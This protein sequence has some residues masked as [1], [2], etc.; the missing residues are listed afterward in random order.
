MN[1]K[2]KK[3]INIYIA[4][5]CILF[6]SCIPRFED[7]FYCKS[8]DTGIKFNIADS[9][10]GVLEIGNSGP[11]KRIDCWL[12]LY[13][14]PTDYS[15]KD[16]EFF[17][18]ARNKSDSL[19][20]K[21]TLFETRN[22]INNPHGLSISSS[23]EFKNL[24]DYSKTIHRESKYYSYE[25]F[26]FEIPQIHFARYNLFELN[27]LMSVNYQNKPFSKKIKEVFIRKRKFHFR[28]IGIH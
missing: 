19:I 13:N 22:N 14:L 11:W 5:I 16:L 18:V 9:I 25:M 8:D 12:I 15:I 17:I 10:S 24:P 21:P 27:L 28:P 26:T 4:T 6:S 2:K 7:S 23:T 3:N 1:N 20:I